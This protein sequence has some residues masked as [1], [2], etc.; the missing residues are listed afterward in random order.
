MKMMGLQDSTYYLS[1]FILF[2]AICL[3]TTIITI[4]MS[5]IGIF[6]NINMFIFF[7]FNMLYALTFYGFFFMIVAFL[8]TSRS[9]GIAATLL[10]IITYYMG[11]ILNDPNSPT[12]AQY[13]L[14]AL[15]NINMHQCVKQIFFY[16]YNTNAGLTWSTFSVDYLG[17]SF[18]NGLLVLVANC[19]FWTAVGLYLDQV[20]PSQ[21][22]VC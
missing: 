17:Y 18:S 14:S 10:H 9:S 21:Y 8:P 22:G 4:A 16:D 13:G 1:W 2:F 15:P 20:V 7:I 3:I 6:R 12:E 5:A 11:F 19:V